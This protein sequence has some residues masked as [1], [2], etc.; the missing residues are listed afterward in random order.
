MSAD[1][2]ISQLS[3][4]LASLPDDESKSQMLAAL[5]IPPTV[6]LIM[7]LPALSP[8]ADIF[9]LLD[10]VVKEMSR[11]SFERKTWDR[12]KKYTDAEMEAELRR[13][14]EN[15]AEEDGGEPDYESWQ[16]KPPMQ[17]K[18]H[19][20]AGLLCQFK[21]M[22][23][24]GEFGDSDDGEDDGGFGFGDSDDEI[25]SDEDEPEDDSPAGKA[26][27]KVQTELE[28]QHGLKLVMLE[29]PFDEGAKA[30][31][32]TRKRLLTKDHL[33]LPVDVAEAATRINQ[34]A[35][36]MC[37]SWGGGGTSLGNA[38]WSRYLH[39]AAAE[40]AGAV[41]AGRHG[42]ALGPL[43]GVL[44]FGISDDG[45]LHDQEEYCEWDGFEHFFR[46]LSL[47]WQGILAQPDESIGLAP[48]LGGGGY[49]AKIVEMLT[50]WEKEVNEKLEDF[51]EFAE[52]G[53]K[54]RLTATKA[55]KSKAAAGKSK[56]AAGS[57]SRK[58]AKK[59]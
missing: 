2:P 15:R 32:V 7:G 39:P 40:A 48:P 50:R 6:K 3:G 13:D 46:S 10:P 24:E 23:E 53:R 58:K 44:F 29:E 9:T 8:E 25:D 55:G 34:G 57:G 35:R 38:L 43:L 54:A 30:A 45:W 33:L 26:F 36:K 52:G 20:L 12:I 1:N 17:R 28:Q 16:S 51:D 18:A 41:S 19:F 27:S 5:P 11:S 59:G 37:Y 42:E 49:R 31:T 22:Q 21:I 14:S 47:S 4:L 56:A